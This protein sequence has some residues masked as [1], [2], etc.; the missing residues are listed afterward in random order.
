MPI[1]DFVNIAQ[2]IE[3]LKD[4]QFTGG[5]GGS[6]AVNPLIGGG[7]S[8][9]NN[10][11]AGESSRSFQ[12]IA[13][14][15]QFGQSA[16]ESLNDLL[17]RPTTDPKPPQVINDAPGT[18]VLAG[19]PQGTGLSFSPQGQG[20]LSPDIAAL[21][22]MLLGGNL[23]GSESGTGGFPGGDGGNGGS[24]SQLGGF[25]GTAVQA[26]LNYFFPESRI[27][28]VLPGGLGNVVGKV[29]GSV[30]GGDKHHPVAF[31]KLEIPE[32]LKDFGIVDVA[33]DRESY[34][35]GG[36]SEA[37]IINSLNS[38]Y[39]RVRD[40]FADAGFALPQELQDFNK[41]PHTVGITGGKTASEIEK[42]T[43]V[44]FSFGR[45]QK[46]NQ[47]SVVFMSAAVAALKQLKLEQGSDDKSFTDIYNENPSI[48]ALYLRSLNQ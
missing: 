28:S 18:A 19:Q 21:L 38:A 8:V 39:D 4:V 16:G 26:A 35:H 37:A 30:F 7:S 12:S 1:N 22:G 20:G 9:L 42:K 2:L 27:L 45:L 40:M 36:E 11:D 17:L 6:Q 32:N 10:Q 48:E 15:Q 3:S 5:G 13:P 29:V 41:L 23:Q 33:V 34:R 47:Q 46:L 44:N 25:A 43:Q 24:Q 31:D 14:G